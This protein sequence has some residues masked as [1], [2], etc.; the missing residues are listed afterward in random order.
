MRVLVWCTSSR[1]SFYAIGKVICLVMMWP[2]PTSRDKPWNPNPPEFQMCTKLIL[3]TGKLYGHVENAWS[4]SSAKKEWG[5]YCIFRKFFQEYQRLTTYKS[6]KLIDHKLTFKITSTWLKADFKPTSRWL[7]SHSKA[8]S[9]MTPDFKMTSDIKLTSSSWTQITT[10]S[11]LKSGPVWSFT[12]FVCNRNH[13]RF[14]NMVISKKIGLKL[15]K[16][17]VFSGPN[18][19]Q[20]RFKP[21]WIGRSILLIY[22]F[23]MSLIWPKTDNIWPRNKLNR[24]ML[25]KITDFK[26]TDQVW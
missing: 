1:L 17:P 9:K 25:S 7:S 24:N 5:K 12:Y 23:K 11:V 6:L 2:I 19:F 10:S 18:R 26:P 21:I 16:K 14:P 3:A 8:T 22:P 20:D 4:I 13:N 15:E